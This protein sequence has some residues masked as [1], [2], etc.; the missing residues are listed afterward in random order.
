MV[1]CDRL[2]GSHFVQ[3][4]ASAK[5]APP[6]SPAEWKGP[7]AVKRAACTLIGWAA[8]LGPVIAGGPLRVP[9]RPPQGPAGSAR[10]ARVGVL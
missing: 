5:L 2:G 4:P 7:A 9:V 6:L 10:S 3:S 1:L 8:Q